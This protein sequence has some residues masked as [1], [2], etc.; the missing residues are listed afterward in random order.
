MKPCYEGGGAGQTEVSRR[1]CRVVWQVGWSH[2]EPPPSW[3]LPLRRVPGQG[4]AS[5]RQ[6]L[7]LPLHC[8]FIYS[9][10]IAASLSAATFSMTSSAA[11]VTVTLLFVASMSAAAAIAIAS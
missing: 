11:L 2:L 5:P 9:P 8:G 6:L 4:P 7:R 10:L 3:S 1:P